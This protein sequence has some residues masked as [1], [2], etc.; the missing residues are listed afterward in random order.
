MVADGIDASLGQYDDDSGDWRPAVNRRTHRRFLIRKAR[1][2]MNAELSEKGEQ[3]GRWLWI[4]G[5]GEGE[6]QRRY[7]A[8]RRSEHGGCPAACWIVSRVAGAA[9]SMV[10]GWLSRRRQ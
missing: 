2:E 10:A 3:L 1:C 8:L 6:A 9:V 7:L 4:A 5:A